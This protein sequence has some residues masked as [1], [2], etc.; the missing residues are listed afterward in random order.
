MQAAPGFD[1]GLIFYFAIASLANYG[2]T[3]AGWA[4]YN[5]WSLLGGLRT[6]SQMMSY[7]V[8]MGLALLGAFLVYGTLEPRRHR[9]R[10]G[11]ELPIALGHRHAAARRAA[12]LHRRDR[13]DQARAVRHP[14]R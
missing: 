10:A 1:V 12:L 9:H 4:C 3:L 11:A 5:K 2:S 14:R 13:R 7:E 6:S 8:T